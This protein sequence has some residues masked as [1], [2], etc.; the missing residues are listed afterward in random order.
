MK[1]GRREERGGG[2][3][4]KEKG[5]ERGGKERKG[6]ERK[7]R[8]E[9]K[10]RNE[11]MS[12]LPSKPIGDCLSMLSFSRIQAERE[13]KKGQTKEIQPGDPT[14]RS[15]PRKFPTKGTPPTKE[16]HQGA[17]DQYVCRFRF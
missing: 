6:K 15:Q 8:K 17:R 4:G 14:R 10:E 9:G 7:E 11:G 2:K 3:E 1:K 16:F 12:K 13:K 5:E